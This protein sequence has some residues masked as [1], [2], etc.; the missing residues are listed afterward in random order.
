MNFRFTLKYAGKPV[1]GPELPFSGT[2][3]EAYT[4]AR[5]VA[6][7]LGKLFPA[8]AFSVR[9]DR[10]DAAMRGYEIGSDGHTIEDQ[11]MPLTA[12]TSRT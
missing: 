4:R 12:T 2:R 7:S 11:K 8:G 10:E 3:L 5:S 1:E 9:V 6:I